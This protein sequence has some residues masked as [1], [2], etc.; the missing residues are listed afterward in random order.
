MVKNPDLVVQGMTPYIKWLLENY[1][2]RTFQSKIQQFYP[3]MVAS[4]IVNR[5]FPLVVYLGDKAMMVDIL[6][7]KYPQ[8]TDEYYAWDQ[9][10]PFTLNFNRNDSNLSG[11]LNKHLGGKD[12]KWI[13]KPSM[14]K[15]GSG[16]LISSNVDKIYNHIKDDPD[17]NEVWSISYYIERPFVTNKRKTHIR[18]FVLINKSG[19]KIGVY[20]M[21]PHLLFMSGLPYDIKDAQEFMNIFF[22]DEVK[23]KLKGK[24]DSYLDKFSD[25][26]NLTNL[27][28]GSYMLKSWVK[29]AKDIDKS[30]V[31]KKY[32]KGSIERRLLSEKNDK[33]MIGYEVLSGCASKMVD[34]EKGNGFY[35]TYI[36]PQINKIVKQTIV[37]IE[38]EIECVNKKVKQMLSIHRIRFHG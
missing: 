19:S 3:Y 9:I 28:K 22:K 13:A 34:G 35:N 11:K 38:D 23:N 17:K 27:A 12:L 6:R 21:E 32:P 2:K 24:V 26:Q 15:Q 30:R 25:F 10:V 16:I 31:E 18:T 20:Q 36:L 1:D 14:G 4:N 5:I 37:S 7:K 29:D 33:S 8:E